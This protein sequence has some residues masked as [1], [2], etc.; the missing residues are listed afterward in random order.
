M[1]LLAPLAVMALMACNGTRP[2]GPTVE[3][4]LGESFSLQ[5]GQTARVT[6][7][8]LRIRFEQVAED[9]RC[10]TDVQCVWA[11]NARV[12]LVVALG[13]DRRELEVNTGVDP[14]A[15]EVDGYSLRLEDLRPHPSTR[16]GIPRGGYTA[17]LVVSQA[18]PDAR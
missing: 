8:D 4:P 9:S 15:V 12:A 13:A 14:R 17:T 2:L 7:S 18:L 16:R 11:G 10:P 6:E 1:R 3:V 5:I